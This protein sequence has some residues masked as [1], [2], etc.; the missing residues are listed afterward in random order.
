MIIGEAAHA[1]HLWAWFAL[2]TASAAVVLHTVIKVASAP[3]FGPDRG[4]RPAEPPGN[5]RAAMGAAAVLCVLPGVAPGMVYELL[6]FPLDYR[7]YTTGH[8]VTQ[9]QLVALASLGYV[10]LNRFGLYPRA[11]DA[12]VLDVD[13]I[14]RRLAPAAI[15]RILAAYR[16]L[17]RNTT[18]LLRTA[19]HRIIASVMHDHRAEGILAQNWPMGSTVLWVAVLLVLYMAFFFL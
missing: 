1:G 5:M 19:T 2:L 9:L 16:L 4:L 13:W 14:Y 3:F 7:P 17:D 8:V 18:G 6:P 12:V 10:L 15:V 11:R